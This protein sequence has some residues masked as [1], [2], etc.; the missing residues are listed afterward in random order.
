MV[1][2]IVLDCE[3]AR[4]S[5]DERAFFKDADPLGFILFARHCESAEAV[6]AHCDELR[7]CLGRDVFILIDQEGGRVTRMKPP[8]FPEHAAPGLIGQLWRLDPNKALEAAHLNAKLLGRMVSDLGV[9][10]N[11]IPSLDAPQME[12]DPAT[13]GDRAFARHRDTIVALGRAAV[14]GSLEG[15]AL[16]VVKHMPGLGRA[17]CDSHL[18]LPRV[19]ASLNDLQTEDFAPFKALNDAPLAMTAHVVYE[20]LDAETPATL[21]QEVIGGVIREQIG[22]DGLLFSDDLKMQAL[23]G[24]YDARVRDALAAGCDVA[25]LC[26]VTLSEKELA[27]KGAAPL[28]GA[29]QARAARAMAFLQPPSHED[30]AADY[31]RLKRLLHPVMI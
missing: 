23:S 25:L 31:D 30:T 9:N 15:G 1:N 19:S 27:M 28:T 7:D 3:G 22:F 20:A 17:L 16:P 10:V 13:L 29:G 11:C 6:R 4:L 8:V 5:D 12:S 24:G 18:D 14:E 21:S 26:N 2:A